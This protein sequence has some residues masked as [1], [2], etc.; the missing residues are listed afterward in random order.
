MLRRPAWQARKKRTQGCVTVR[1]PVPVRIMTH[2]GSRLKETPIALFPTVTVSVAV[3]DCD[4]RCDCWC[5]WDY[6]CDC[7]CDWDCGCGCGCGCCLLL[8]WVDLRR[9]LVPPR[10]TAQRILHTARTR[11]SRALSPHL[12]SSDIAHSVQLFRVA[13]FYPPYLPFSIPPQTL[14]LST[15]A[16]TSEAEGEG[17]TAAPGKKPYGSISRREGPGQQPSNRRPKK[18]YSTAGALGQKSQGR[19]SRQKPLEQS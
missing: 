7:D 6:G 4:C 9:V 19:S 5:E 12:P 2:L 18:A 11:I 16:L 1:S 17:E 3:A 13:L 8:C 10:P 14:A 15:Q